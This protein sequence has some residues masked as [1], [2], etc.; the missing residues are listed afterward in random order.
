[1]RET[2]KAA[3]AGPQ[4]VRKSWKEEQ[5]YQQQGSQQGTLQPR[6]QGARESFPQGLTVKL[7]ATEGHARSPGVSL[8]ML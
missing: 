6:L 1:M 4:S 5:S 7:R 3:L 8:V 2:G